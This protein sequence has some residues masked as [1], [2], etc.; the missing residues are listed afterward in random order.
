MFV[1]PAS[2]HALALYRLFGRLV[3]LSPEY[4]DLENFPTCE[5]K[6]V[7]TRLHKKREYAAAQQRKDDDPRR[8]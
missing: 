2:Y 7:L 8:R 5:A 1:W 4:Y 3:D 6:I